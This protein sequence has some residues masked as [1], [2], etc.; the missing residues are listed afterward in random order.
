MRG[1]GKY[2]ERLY[3]LTTIQIIQVLLEGPLTYN[4]I[5]SKT[6]I[7]GTRL[8]QNFRITCKKRCN[9]SS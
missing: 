5:R 6:R 4:E 7:Q 2:Q 1:K 8:K 3:K 9:N